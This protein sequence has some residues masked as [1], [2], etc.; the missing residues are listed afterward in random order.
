MKIDF[1]PPDITEEEI[2][3]V[4]GVLRSGWIT[5]GPKT[6]E[7]ERKIAE[8]CGAKRAVCLNSAT[9]CMEMTLRALGIGAGDEVITTA[10]TYTATASVICHVGA[11]PVFVDTAKDSYQMDYDALHRAINKKTKVVIPVDIGGVPCDYERLFDVLEDKK[12]LFEPSNPLQ[13]IFDRIV[14]LADAAHSFG[15][16]CEGKKSGAFADFTSFS[17][18]AVKNLTTGEGGGLVWRERP[19]MDME[20]LYKKFMLLSLH[21]QTKDALEKSKVQ[22]NW[23]Y[24]IV[25]PSYKCNMTDLTAAIGLVQ[26]DRYGDLL[27]K[28]RKIVKDYNV[29]LGLDSDGCKESDAF[30]VLRHEGTDYASSC[31]L[32]LVRLMG[33]D[34]A[35]VNH[36]MEEMA[37]AGIATNV[38]YKPLPMLTAYRNMGFDVR[39]YP[40][41]MDM[42]ENGMTL[43]LHTGLTEEEV[44]YITDSLLAI[45][46]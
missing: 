42:Y 5:T 13:D 21:G 26:L 46:R 10:Y 20:G 23:E 27:N 15:A 19:G 38:H 30:R 9:A 4:S 39:D 25:E 6:K 17:F 28:R 2:D 22:G 1:S 35:Y 31:H 12:G 7:F 11:T 16:E 36:V 3:A 8:Y 40:N 14:V 24:D 29:R 33:R 43:P 44:G 18:H 41:A 45:V 34:R 32:Y 37:K